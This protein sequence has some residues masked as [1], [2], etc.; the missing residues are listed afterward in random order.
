V[1][2]LVR[3]V[4]ASLLLNRNAFFFRNFFAIL[5]RFLV[6]LGELLFHHPELLDWK[7]FGLRKLLA[8][9]R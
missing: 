9:F 8:G 6:A 2:I 4:L 5:I 1:T 3:F 7:A